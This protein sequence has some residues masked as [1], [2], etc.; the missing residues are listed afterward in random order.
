MEIPVHDSQAVLLTLRW[1]LVGLQPT[2]QD[3]CS[4]GDIGLNWLFHVASQRLG[5]FVPVVGQCMLP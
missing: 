3:A 1:P 2:E 5:F 4:S